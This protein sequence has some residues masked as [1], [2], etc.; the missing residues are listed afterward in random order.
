MITIMTMETNDM[1]T[2]WP[3]FEHVIHFQIPGAHYNYCGH[4]WGVPVFVSSEISSG[5]GIVWERNIWYVFRSDR[6]PQIDIC[7]VRTQK[8]AQ[9]LVCGSLGLGFLF[10]LRGGSTFTAYAVLA[11]K[12]L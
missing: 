3:D 1:S 6:R 2:S 5:S 10:G 12:A 8:W 9:F 7:E 11:N 4:N